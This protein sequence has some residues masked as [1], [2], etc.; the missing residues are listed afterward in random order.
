MQKQNKIPNKNIFKTKKKIFPNQ[1]IS[2]K[3][4]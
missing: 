1:K 4:K 2:K 3:N